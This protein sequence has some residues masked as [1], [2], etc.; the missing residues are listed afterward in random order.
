MSIDTGT[1]SVMTLDVGT[2][3]DLS[4]VKGSLLT[5]DGGAKGG[6]TR[7]GGVRKPIRPWRSD[8]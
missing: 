8:N 7:V 1:G 4:F 2:V 3:K 6:R 5:E